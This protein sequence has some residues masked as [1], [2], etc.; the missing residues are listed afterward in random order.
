M[1]DPAI[2]RMTADYASAMAA[3]VG[4]HNAREAE[5]AAEA[6]AA[7]QGALTRAWDY[8]AGLFVRAPEDAA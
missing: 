8:V 6:D 7:K 3:R 2:P 5:K 4:A 1:D